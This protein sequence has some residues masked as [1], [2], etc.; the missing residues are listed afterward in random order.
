MKRKI[1]PILMTAALLSLG[2]GTLAYAQDFTPAPV[3]GHQLT[4]MTDL[5]ARAHILIR[6]ASAGDNAWADM[7]GDKTFQPSE[8]L[9]QNESHVFTI[10]KQ[11]IVI[12]GDLTAMTSWGS[13][14]TSIDLSN[15]P[16]LQT[17]GCMKNNLKELDL[18]KVPNLEQFYCWYNQLTTLDLSKT[19]KLKEL[20]VSNNKL[21]S[22]DISHL[23]DLVEFGCY[24]NYIKEKAMRTIVQALPV[25]EKGK[26]ARFFPY[27]P[28]TGG[29]ENN[30]CTPELVKIA[31]DK[32]WKVLDP[33]ADHDFEGAPSGLE[34]I[35]KSHL[36][37]TLVAKD[38]ILSIAGLEAGMPIELYTLDGA[39]L[40][41][42][43]AEA[44][45]VSI[46][47]PVGSYVLRIGDYSAKVVMPS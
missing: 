27:E 6:V 38:G 37:I 18:S 20:F 9:N 39:M 14:I 17:L 40:Y 44:R 24:S 25:I 35:T 3:K 36:P 23:S 5:P 13:E 28:A 11:T 19:P 22:L 47:L 15:V 1:T 42:N 32:N 31:K 12:Y 45:N 16:N 7:N 21:K 8:R 46:A 41:H 43:V 26:R 10:D 33:N 29:N 30:D 2:S 4:F 34:D